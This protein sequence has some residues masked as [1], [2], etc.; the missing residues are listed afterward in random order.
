[1]E[2]HGRDPSY[3]P[4][5]LDRTVGWFTSLY[6]VRLPVRA[7]R[8]EHVAAIREALRAV[9]EG[10]VG[11][12]LLAHL[13]EPDLR[14]AVAAP[15]GPVFNYLGRI[16]DAMA[17]GAFTLAAEDAGPE[18][19]PEALMLDPLRIDA[20][21]R[22]GQ[23]RIDWM[24]DPV[25]HDAAEAERIVA[26]FEAALRRLA[27]AEP[28]ISREV[29]SYPLTP[30]QQ[31]LLFHARL[32][33]GDTAYVNLLAVTF[34]GLDTNRFRAAWRA[35]YARHDILRSTFHARDGA[36]LEQVVHP[37]VEPAFEEHDWRGMP[38]LEGRL[39]RLGDAERARGFDLAAAPP[40][41]L[42]L[43][44]TGEA[45]WRFLWVRHHI[46]L[47]GWSSARLL[48]ELAAQYRG[49][50]PHGPAPRFRDAVAWLARRDRAADR[51]YW[52]AALASV[53]EPFRLSSGHAGPPGRGR[54]LIRLDAERT[55]AL[56]VAARAKRITLATLVQAAWA[57]VLARRTGR[58]ALFGVTIAGRPDVLPGAEAMLGLFINTLPV[59]TEPSAD[60]AIGTYLADLQGQNL[61]L[62]EHG[63][64]PLFEV[65]SLAGN[66]GE[67]LFD[68][69]L[70]FENYP[71]DP[72]LSVPAPGALA[73]RDVL[74]SEDTHYP[75]PSR[76]R[77]ARRRPS[78]W[79][80]PRR[81]SRLGTSR[82][83][84]TR[85]TGRC[86]P[87]RRRRTRRCSAA[88]ASRPRVIARSRGRLRRPS[89]RSRPGCV[90]MRKRSGTDRGRGRRRPAQLCRTRPG[91]GRRGG[92]SRRS[93]VRRGD[94]VG[95]FLG[96]GTAMV[97]G[98]LGIVK[99][100]AA[101]VPL[102]PDYPFERLTFMA[103]DAGLAALLTE[104]A[105]CAAAPAGPWAMLDIEGRRRVRSRPSRP[106]P[107]IS[108]T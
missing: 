92:A 58:P 98:L 7:D 10:G 44:R 90:P 23:L 75:S 79:L 67:A 5:D 73:F 56:R 66:G 93:G 28:A 61:A 64:I 86:P 17:G 49:E 48:A 87:S 91:F 105:L 1:M 70:I 6:P 21:L 51:A 37:R 33:P 78:G 88:S 72:K 97:L 40:M 24:F 34:D 47:D 14:A 104:P 96:R 13:A 32:A 16:D 57:L 25:R 9:P 50:A 107:T 80:T 81:R 43:V 89:S 15:R 36:E 63:A 59:L 74:V 102:D 69:V 62:R 31:G 52:R 2:G 22:D 84:P 41:R 26:A 65:Q 39:A 38:D 77:W 11:Y 60:R 4:S 85:S 55:D 46:L 94:R 29:E 19:D 42:V 83:S 108:L 68:T 103:Q 100:G 95:V 27:G 20:R 71:V 54:H 8:A 53:E 101:Y 45:K 30:M 3:A 106:I 76:W 35:A 82:R 99:A 12:G 18:R